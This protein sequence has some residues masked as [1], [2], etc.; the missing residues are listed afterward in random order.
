MSSVYDLKNGHSTEPRGISAVRLHAM[1]EKLSTATSST[2]DKLHE[3]SVICRVA[4]IN[5]MQPESDRK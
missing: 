4:G 5:P 2:K 1:I 3:A